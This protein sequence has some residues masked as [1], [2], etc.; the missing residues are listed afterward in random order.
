MTIYQKFFTRYE[1]KYMISVYERDVVLQEISP[2]VQLDSFSKNLGFYE[3]KNLYFDSISKRCFYEKDNGNPTRHKLRFR[4]YPNSQKEKENSSDEKIIFI[5]L[6]SKSI[7][8]VLKKRI[9]VPFSKAFD[10]I[11]TKTEISQRFYETLNPQ[12]KKTLNDIW[13]LQKSYQLKP[14]CAV[15][16]QRKAFFSPHIRNL[17]IT[18]D[19]NVQSKKNELNLLDNTGYKNIIPKNMCIMEVKFNEKIPNWMTNLIHKIDCFQIGISKF[20]TSIE[21]TYLIF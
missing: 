18:F 5:E 7:D 2:F 4:Y 20:A 10:I 3:V 16:Y 17:R 9:I 15:K 13:Y 19:T 6:K 14:V 1:I 11:D 21:K 12:D 8:N